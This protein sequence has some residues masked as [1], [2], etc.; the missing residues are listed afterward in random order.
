[1]NVKSIVSLLWKSLLGLV[2]VCL[3]ACSAPADA[4]HQVEIGMSVQLINDSQA[5]VDREFDLMSS[6]HTTWV[7]ADFDWSAVEGQRGQYNWAYADRLAAAT[8]KRGMKI[9]AVLAYTPS[10]ARP[11]GT[12]T[13]YPPS[14]FSNFARFASA[15]AARFGPDQ[16]GAWEIWNEQNLAQFW[17]PL[18]NASRYS[19][20]FRQTASAIRQA[21]PGAVVLTGGL[22]PGSDLPGGVRVSQRSFVQQLYA[23]GAA[24]AASGVAIHPYSFPR[25][26]TDGS[27]GE[28]SFADLP[29]IHSLMD[30]NGDGSK[31]IWLTEFGAPTG[32]GAVAVSEDAQKAAILDARSQAAQWD[33]TGP[34][35]YYELRDSGTNAA[36]LE[37]NFGVVRFD[38]T[39]KPAGQALMQ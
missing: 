34:L 2:A 32:T 27:A 7:R 36:E 11:A 16:V 8:R 10:W 18:P 22:S 3:A 21:R 33:W 25:L 35:V 31:R 13:H 5:T 6:M 15:A 23:N 29:S 30:S 24:Q 12:N 1:M 26:P 9:L 38:F 4:T 39:P 14:D 37:Q 17:Q 19:S 20:L 28:G